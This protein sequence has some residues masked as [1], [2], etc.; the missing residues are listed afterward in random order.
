MNV[1]Q[2]LAEYAREKAQGQVIDD[3][4]VGVGYTGVKLSDGTAGVSY[5]FRNSLGPACGV[6][7]HAGSLLGMPVE[8]ALDWAMSENLAEASVGVAT[9]NAI[10]NQGFSRGANI[11]EAVECDS[12]DIVGMV[13][14]FCPLV[15]KYQNAAKFYI[16][17]KDLR[18]DEVSGKNTVVM[19]AAA[20]EAALSQCTR[21]VLTGTSFINKTAD[22][23]LKACKNARE[24]IIVGAST[25]M[26]PEILREYGV[27]I[28]AGT[29]ITDADKA[30]R[31]VAQG[32]GGMDI[33]PASIKLLERI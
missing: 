33:S 4:C 10:I 13:G 14:Y 18:Q 22:G 5:T 24:I 30:L 9:M 28:L 17:D 1:T 6:L 7:K 12:T 2:R 20:D 19:C 27:T 31:I 21:V 26:C 11:A 32:G 25:P 8:K 23:L 3:L 29:Q 16:F 15:W